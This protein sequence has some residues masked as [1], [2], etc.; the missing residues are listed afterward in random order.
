M[1]RS[2]DAAAPSQI[3]APQIQLV[4]RTNSL[5]RNQF[6]Q[7]G[8]GEHAGNLG[9]DRSNCR[10]L[11]PTAMPNESWRRVRIAITPTRGTRDQ[12]S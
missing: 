11:T 8:F 5:Q 1:M 9:T 6:H 12:S 10:I 4:K 7:S 3:Q 2:A